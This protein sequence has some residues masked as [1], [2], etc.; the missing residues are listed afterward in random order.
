MDLDAIL[1]DIAEFVEGCLGPLSGNGDI[2]SWLRDFVIQLIATLILF[3]VVKIFLWKPITAFLEERRDK[4]DEDLIEAEKAKERAL[5]IEEEL[6]EKYDAAKEEIQKL[7]KK[8]E[9]DGNLRREQIILE[10][11]QE[12]HRLV[13][14][15]KEDIDNQIA[16]QEQEIKNQIVSI[17]FLAAEAIVGKEI[18]HE[19]YLQTVI[20]I[21]E[22]G[23]N[24][25]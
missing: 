10:A 25:E 5:K 8:A 17:A 20:E 22:S 11:K 7:L 21:I 16:Q 23:M 14:V 19:Q 24:N 6:K 3:I 18:D 15:A 12:A 13:N 1:R 4:M 9:A 2:W